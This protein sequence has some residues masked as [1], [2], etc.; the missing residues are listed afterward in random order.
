MTLFFIEVTS[1]KMDKCIWKKAYRINN[2]K[3]KN[4]MPAHYS[5]A[6]AAMKR[7]IIENR[8]NDAP[9]Q[10]YRTLPEVGKD[11]A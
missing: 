7:W 5:M 1:L 3:V 2:G 4:W 10:S 6:D 11:Q 9:D 8:N